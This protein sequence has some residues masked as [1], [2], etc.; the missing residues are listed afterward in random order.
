[1]V[2]GSH[3][4]AAVAREVLQKRKS[5]RI[6]T[7]RNGRDIYTQ[8]GNTHL[9]NIKHLLGCLLS[10]VNSNEMHKIHLVR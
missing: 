2:G 6:N 5:A 10:K 4:V 7:E 1:M 8:L 9:V 3:N